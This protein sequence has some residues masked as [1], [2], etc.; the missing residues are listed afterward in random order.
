MFNIE[1]TIAI[2]PVFTILFF[3]FAYTQL[4][5]AKNRIKNSTRNEY[6]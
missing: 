3:S 6:L 5:V 1:N 4:Y 2:T